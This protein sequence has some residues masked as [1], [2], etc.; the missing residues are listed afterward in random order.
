MLPL[1]FDLINRSHQQYFG[2]SEVTE[3]VV[4]DSEHG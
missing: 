2:E 3:R 1:S 4:R